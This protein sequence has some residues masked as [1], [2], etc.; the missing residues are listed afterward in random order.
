MASGA[1]TTATVP[2]ADLLALAGGSYTR[3]RGEHSRGRAAVESPPACLR[4]RRTDRATA[5]GVSGWSGGES[6]GAHRHDSR[7]QHWQRRG[8][9]SSIVLGG[10]G[11][12]S[13]R[14]GG[15]RRRRRRIRRSLLLLRGNVAVAFEEL[16]QV[17][18][19]QR[20]VGRRA[21]CG[22]FIFACSVSQHHTN[23]EVR[24]CAAPNR[25]TIAHDP[26]DSLQ[27]DSTRQEC[28]L[29]AACRERYSGRAGKWWTPPLPR[30]A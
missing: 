28:K 26:L 30:H 25:P 2:T 24:A 16:R 4:D 11:C 21:L 23:K 10:L 7:G 14:G 12:G 20:A 27:L 29:S 3:L 18:L 22:G 8:Q 6:R 5:G 9:R 13:R 1:L 17:V 15:R 19:A